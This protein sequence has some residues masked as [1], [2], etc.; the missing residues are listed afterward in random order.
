MSCVAERSFSDDR[1]R[2]V[3]LSLYTAS[4]FK[5]PHTC[6]QLLACGFRTLHMESMYCRE[7]AGQPRRVPPANEHKRSHA[8]ESRAQPFHQ[9]KNAPT[10]SWTTLSL[11]ADPP[12]APSSTFT[13][14]YSTRKRRGAA[15]TR[16]RR[17]LL[18]SKSSPH[19][20]MRQCLYVKV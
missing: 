14:N 9:N 18:K 7:N 15:A 2:V 17:G 8:V 6:E 4:A 12:A 5:L 16:W 13:D 1:S 19:S 3:S 10:T 20:V 11:A